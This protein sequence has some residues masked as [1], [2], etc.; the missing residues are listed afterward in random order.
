MRITSNNVLTNSN[1]ELVN[2]WHPTKNK[3]L[4]TEN[5]LNKTS[6]N[7]FIL[8][9]DEM[10]DIRQ[11]CLLNTSKYFHEVLKVHPGTSLYITQ[12]WLN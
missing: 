9:S 12:S 7:T 5:T 11:F 1:P 2:E 8:N 3:E 10:T 4:T 6:Q